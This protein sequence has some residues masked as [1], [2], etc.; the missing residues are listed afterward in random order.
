MLPARRIPYLADVG[1]LVG[2][3]AL[4]AIF[5]AHG[6]Q[7][8][9]DTGHEGVTKGFEAMGIPLPGLAA[10]YATWVELVGGIALVVGVLVPVAGLLLLLDMIGAFWFVHMDKGLFVS[11]GGYELVLILGATAL[12]LACTGSGRFGL[13][14]LLFGRG[15]T[16]DRA[17][18][19][20]A[21]A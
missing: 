2:R 20:H 5:I 9:I 16:R 19:E 14:A 4:G 11:E 1:L 6:W 18:R 3:V 21:R 7:K 17:D 10:H 15:D 12:M 8:L 13:D